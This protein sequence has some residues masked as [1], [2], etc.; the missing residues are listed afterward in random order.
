MSA[1][2]APLRRLQRLLKEMETLDLDA[3]IITNPKHV[4]YFTGLFAPSLLSLVHSFALP[5]YLIVFRDGQSILL[6]P[7]RDKE[8]AEKVF[9]GDV[10]SYV[11]YNLQMHMVPNPAYVAS[12]L[13][14]LLS[15]FGSPLEKVGVES[16]TIP[17]TLLQAVCESNEVGVHDLS[18]SILRM[19]ATKDT[20]ELAAIREGSALSDFAVFGCKISVDTRQI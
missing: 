9:G 5:T 16:W 3:S 6:T 17:Q 1:K 19:R 11:N 10:A 20:D 8:I 12:E 7:Q 15:R 13:K 2:R 4:Y 14:K 18:S